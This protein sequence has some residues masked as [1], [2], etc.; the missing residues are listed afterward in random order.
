MNRENHPG[1]RVGC[2]CT[3]LNQSNILN[4]II[5]I[6][7]FLFQMLISKLEK[8]KSPE[9]KSKIMKVVKVLVNVFNLDGTNFA[10]FIFFSHDYLFEMYVYFDVVDN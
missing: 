9:E 10:N 6:I 3:C 5:Y 4:N 1:E 7:L 8:T 2:T